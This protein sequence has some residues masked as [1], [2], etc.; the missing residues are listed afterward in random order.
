MNIK[1]IIIVAIALVSLASC[2]K[3]LLDAAPE[4]VVSDATAFDQPYRITN[5]VLSLYSLLKNG[6]IYGG[7]VLVY[8]DI[9]GEDFLMEDPNGVT[10]EDICACNHTIFNNIVNNLWTQ[11]ISV[12]NHVN[13]FIDGMNAKCL[14]VVGTAL[15]NNYL[16]EARLIRALTYYTLLQYYARPYADGN[17]SKP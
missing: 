4:T 6:Q 3:D 7:R 14:S 11:S 13:V 1:K 16:G 9:R 12:I 8:G 17:G 15:C 5:Q 10:G 2:R